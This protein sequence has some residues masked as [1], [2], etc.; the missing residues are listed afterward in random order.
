MRDYRT[1]GIRYEYITSALIY[2]QLVD[3]SDLLSEIQ[4]RQIHNLILL[5]NVT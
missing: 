4:N 2:T 5:T 1:N 3:N